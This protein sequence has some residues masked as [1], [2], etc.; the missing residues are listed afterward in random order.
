M[1]DVLVEI[2]QANNPFLILVAGLVIGLV[3]AFEPDH[4]S[5]VSTQILNNNNNRTSKKTNLKILTV[6]SSFKGM[7]WGMGHT[8]S[9][10]LIG[11]LIAGLSLS[12]S[13]TF[14]LSAEVIV[15]SM[16]IFLGIMTAADKSILRQ[17]HTHPHKH[18]NGI[19]HTHPHAHNTD[20][21]HGHKSYIIGCIHGL[22]GSGSIVALAASTMG[23][24]DIV[25]YFLVL[26]G[27]GSIVG[28]A[29]ASGVL[30]ISFMLLLPKIHL[31]AK[32]VRYAIAGV[33]LVV[34]INIIFTVGLKSDLFLLN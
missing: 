21:K 14:F 10:V 34:G 32:Y 23:S 4:I 3:H 25:V 11:L 28:M 24:F 7:L 17:K 27:I 30:G 22:A 5:A 8:S 2:L 1:I 6:L 31:A 13:D 19:S 9:I 26:F 18:P 20:H 29:L 12:I 33:T 15:G 16:L